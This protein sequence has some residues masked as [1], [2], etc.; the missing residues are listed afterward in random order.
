[1]REGRVET[2]DGA[3]LGYRA[4]GDPSAPAVIFANGIGVDHPGATL[5]REAL[6]D[7][8]FITFDYRGVGESTVPHPEIDVSMG[9]H[10]QDLRLGM[11]AITVQ[12]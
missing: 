2:D 4:H 5:Q 7:Y 10:A 11:M 1:M 6:S 8:Q 12:F 3:V 9:R